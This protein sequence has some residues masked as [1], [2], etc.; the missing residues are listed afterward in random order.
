MLI[1]VG[2]V[3]FALVARHL[4]VERFGAYALVL[5]I[6]P[7]LATLV[8]FGIGTTAVRE[9]ARRP[10]DAGRIVSTA[11]TVV[12]AAAAAGALLVLLAV[13]LSPYGADV[14]GALAIAA[15]ALFA[16]VLGSVPGI[17]FQST[18]RLER[19]ALVD[20]T[21]GV[22]T[23]VLV[24]AVIAAGGGL[25]A[26]VAAWAAAVAA[27]VALGYVLALRLLPFRP[28]FERPL[29]GALVRQA[30]PIGLAFIASAVHFRIDAVLLSLMQ[31][32][33]DVGVYGA[34]FRFLE[35]SLY[36]PLLFMST[37][38]PILAGFVARADPRLEGTIQR[39]FTFL[40]L[41]ALPAAV[42]TVLLAGP[43]V[44]L[45]V[46]SGY[47]EAATTLRILAVAVLFAFLNPLFTNILVA[48]DLQARMLAATLLAIVVNVVLNLVLIPAYTYN[49]A[50]VATVI[51][52]AVA[53]SLVA[54]WAVRHTGARLEWRVAGRIAAATA[55]M[56]AVVA[57]L[58]DLPLVVPVLGGLLVYGLL[59]AALRIVTPRQVVTLLRAQ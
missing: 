42:G 1:A 5:S 10:D 55:A 26:I 36:A 21:S 8:D 13:P 58:A 38:F 59:L 16:L 48:A 7:L 20:L 2:L 39:A 41:L 45:L 51:S 46:G 53:V 40:L 35:H 29:A 24:V 22:M 34:A 3:T 27:A 6:V 54:F 9:I 25:H 32:I 4:G 56:G 49:G 30:L 43:L 44:A 15:A 12:A 17:V 11:L 47:E 50:A 33:E 18:L 52:E 31:P 37:L 28:R 23:L 57:L 19:Q 14:R